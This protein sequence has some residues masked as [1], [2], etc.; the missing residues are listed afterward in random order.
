MEKEV[1][2][3]LVPL[4]FAI[5]EMCGYTKQL[6]LGVHISDFD[7]SKLNL[8]PCELNPNNYELMYDGKKFCLFID[9]FNGNIKKSRCFAEEEWVKVKDDCLIGMLFEIFWNIRLKVEELL[10]QKENCLCFI[11]WNR[12]WLNF[13]MRVLL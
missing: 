5:Y 10:S 1:G 11:E 7:K 2:I 8:S 6:E 3:K 13:V 4:T 9:A 12:I